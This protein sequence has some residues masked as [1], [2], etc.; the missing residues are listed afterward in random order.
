MINNLRDNGL[1]PSTRVYE[2]MLVIVPRLW[3]VVEWRRKWIER[4]LPPLCHIMI[5]RNLSA[6]AKPY[7]PMGNWRD[8]C[9]VDFG[10]TYACERCFGFGGLCRSG[11][12]SP[13][14]RLRIRISHCCPTTTMPLLNGPADRGF[15]CWAEWF[16]QAAKSLGLNISLNFRSWQPRILPRTLNTRN[17]W[18]KGRSLSS[19]VTEDWDTPMR[20]QLPIHKRGKTEDVGPYDA[21]HVGA[22]AP[23]CPTPSPCPSKYPANPCLERWWLM[24]EDAYGVNWTT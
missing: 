7:L 16:N 8:W 19:R 20:V 22:A 6:R 10:T 17:C 2:A 18:T 4:I 23:V 24:V 13:W 1:I 9:R 5:P 12:Q 14:R 15:R 3:V 21:I 11:S